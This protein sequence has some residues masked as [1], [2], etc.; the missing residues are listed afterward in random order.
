M[1]ETLENLDN[2]LAEV[3]SAMS[4]DGSASPKSQASKY[5]VTKGSLDG[6]SGGEV[7]MTGMEK[8]SNSYN[9]TEG[10]APRRVASRRSSAFTLPADYQPQDAANDTPAARAHSEPATAYEDEPLTAVAP[11]LELVLIGALR[12]LT[13]ISRAP[14]P[15]VAG[16]S[17]PSLVST[18]ASKEKSAI[19]KTINYQRNV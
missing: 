6:E 16:L 13:L 18:K 12:G 15:P 5:A 3:E 9:T 19:V 7:E 11:A 4:E 8:H 2:L 17:P 14:P 10:A 1:S